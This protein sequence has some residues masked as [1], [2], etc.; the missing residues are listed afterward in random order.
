[1][2]EYET[3]ADAM[4]AVSASSSAAAATVKW[5]FSIDDAWLP[6]DGE[7]C[8]RL[9]AAQAAGIDR[10]EI[11]IAG[12]LYVVDLKK[13]TQRNVKTNREVGIRRGGPA[14]PAAKAPPPPAAVEHPKG[15]MQHVA[16]LGGK[17]R[18]R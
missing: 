14:A 4:Q 15:W 16:R 5:W 6:H 10:F 7:T 18:R 11:T 12:Q 1:M 17:K 3:I 13:L 9:D 8:D 2:E